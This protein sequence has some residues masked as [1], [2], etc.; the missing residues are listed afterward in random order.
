MLSIKDRQIYENRKE[1]AMTNLPILSNR[2]T[3]ITTT[4]EEIELRPDQ[5]TTDFITSGTAQVLPRLIVGQ[6][7]NDEFPDGANQLY[8]R[9]AGVGIDE[10]TGERKRFLQFAGPYGEKLQAWPVGK[11]MNRLLMPKYRP[12]MPKEESMPLCK[13]NN[14]RIPDAAYM[15]K[16]W[17]NCEVLD[18]RTG[19]LTDK[20]KLACPKCRWGEQGE[21]PECQAIY[22]VCL[23][24]PQPDPF[25]EEPT[26]GVPREWIV[27]EAR[28]KSSR[29]N[30]GKTLF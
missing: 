3:I 13:S 27:A 18:P 20:S 5:D 28:F 19:K 22:V 16:Y 30:S 8:V 26:S 1:N 17:K 23:A 9:Y 29:A 11:T 12:G 15:G 6:P 14:A 25:G 24:F 21:P 7:N 10:K 2:Q 4:G